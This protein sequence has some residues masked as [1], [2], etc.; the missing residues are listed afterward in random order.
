MRQQI[1]LYVR[2]QKIRVP[3]SALSCAL[4][5]LVSALVLAAVWAY[6]WQGREQLH[7]EL[8]VLKQEQKRLQKEFD[9]VRSKRVVIQE[10]PQ[11]QAE[12]AGLNREIVARQK[13]S[14]LLDQ[15]QP[16][17]RLVFSNMLKGLSARVVDGLWLTRIQT[18]DASGTLNLEG[19]TLRAELVPRYLKLLGNEDAWQ[20]ARFDQLQLQL[21]Q[22]EQG[23]S[24]RVSAQL[25]GGS[26]YE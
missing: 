1:N 20:L 24:F 3:F 2:Q 22:A 8:A 18:E 25:R 11:L 15:L 26:G 5:L 10:S 17:Q 21:E 12:L 7:S 16:D 9:Q 4:I 6:N 14:A 23:L 13:Y 19:G